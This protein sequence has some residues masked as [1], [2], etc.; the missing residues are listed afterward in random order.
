MRQDFFETG[1]VI[2]DG[3]LKLQGRRVW[4]QALRRFP[5]GPVVVRVE[6]QKRRRTLRQNAFWHA[7]VIPLFAE[8]C[9][10]DFEDMKDA[11]ALELLPV[12]VTNMKTGKVTV[13][14]GHTSTLTTARFNDLIERAQRLGAEMNLYIPDPG[15]MLT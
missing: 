1:G 2:T 7:V 5:E 3:K 12:E 8:H 13:V 15:E 11:L 4:E 6:A 10:Y 9:G 14:P